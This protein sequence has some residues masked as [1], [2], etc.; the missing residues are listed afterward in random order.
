MST[1]KI[2]SEVLDLTDT[3]AFTGTVTGAG[4]PNIIWV[5]TVKTSTFTAVAGNG[6]FIN[7]SG[8]V[9][10]VNLP[11]GNAGDEIAIVDYAKTFDN[12][13]CS[14]APNGSEKMRSI[15]G[16][17]EMTTEGQATHLVYVDAT[18]G[19]VDT[20]DSTGDLTAQSFIVATGG[21][22]TTTGN[23]KMHKFTGP[24]TFD[25]TSISG[26]AANNGVSYLVVAGGGSGPA[27]NGGE[28][29]S[30]GGGGGGYRESNNVPIDPYTVSPLNAPGN[31]LT[32]SVQGY[33][34]SIGAG[35]SHGTGPSAPSW[36]S[37]SPSIFST[38]TSAGGGRGGRG[39]PSANGVAG[40]SGGGGDNGSSGAAGNTPPT[41]PPQGNAG[42]NAQVSSGGG[43]GG[44]TAIG[45]SP[46]PTQTGGPGG[47]GGTTNII[48]SPVA[49]SGGGGGGAQSTAAVGV[50]GTGGGQNGT[51]ANDPSPTTRNA[52]ANTGGGGGGASDR[53]G[54]TAGGN[55]GS[56]VVIIRYK[57][58]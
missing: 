52:S 3:Y 37:G 1:T 15:A 32:V 19:W 35:G 46:G 36:T 51:N 10:T 55:G 56:G 7:T 44:A 48:A 4:D 58:Q 27:T 42:A 54:G 25:V 12:N 9:I 31:G 2:T 21:T 29:I 53:S 6:Y 8:G 43:G 16:L 13:T 39:D 28:G 34:I 33:P 49:Y 45:T 23:F 26:T 41:S 40:G 47:A 11:A 57:Y 20:T 50:G 17:V 18:Q 30:G 22:I 5:T 14:V 38:I 24:G